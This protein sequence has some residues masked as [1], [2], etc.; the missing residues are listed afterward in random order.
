LFL[1]TTTAEGTAVVLE[2]MVFWKIVDTLTAARNAMEIL[3]I[4][5]KGP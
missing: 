4:D 3:V 2:A 1:H 5:E